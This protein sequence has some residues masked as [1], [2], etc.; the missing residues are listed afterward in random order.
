MVN[1]DIFANNIIGGSNSVSNLSQGEN[2]SRW[3][4]IK[5][6]KFFV[7]KK[8]NSTQ[9]T[10]LSSIIDNNIRGNTDQG[11]ILFDPNGNI[12]VLN[13]T[14]NQVSNIIPNPL[15]D[16][17]NINDIGINVKNKKSFVDTNAAGYCNDVNNI[18]SLPGLKW[19]LHRDSSKEMYILYNPMHRKNVKDYYD[20]VKGINSLG[21]GQMSNLIQQYSNA[22]TVR[23]L[24][25]TNKETAVFSDPSCKCFSDQYN[26]VND[27][28]GFFMN[29]NDKNVVAWN[30]TC[31]APGCKEDLVD[32]TSS[33]LTSFVEKIQ[34]SN[35]ITNC[36]GKISICSMDIRAGG[37]VNLSS[38]QI[39]QSCGNQFPK[40]TEAPP[41]QPPPKQPQ[42]QA[43]N[44][45]P[46]EQDPN[47]QDPDQPKI[48]IQQSKSNT[49]VIIGA[50][51]GG[52]ALI[53]IL[54]IA[55]IKLKNS[56]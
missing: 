17:S 15:G 27:Y 41:K 50:S 46:N 26:C 34:S 12:A 21:D 42:T 40:T 31:G 29:G 11:I 54:L 55:Y 52:L 33:F 32:K 48:P 56:V 44:Q 24:S 16:Q 22:F 51:L 1:L 28:A 7:V 4:K 45:D 19:I 37:N 47:E 14:D 9:S 8:L 49:P 35:N 10:L 23:P 3:I 5:S 53:I 2:P 43:P 20:S 6:S 25:I 18:F 39:D 30:C 38:S 13:V 36:G